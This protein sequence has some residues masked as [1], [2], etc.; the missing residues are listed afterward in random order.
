MAKPDWVFGLHSVS[1]ILERH[2]E[3]ILEI[4]LMEGR[5]DQ[6][7]S[8]V[9]SLADQQDITYRMVAKKVL[10]DIVR[11]GNHQGVAAKCRLA[12]P[13]REQDLLRAVE[14]AREP[15]LFLVLDSVTDPQ[16]LGGCI[17]SL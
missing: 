10:D 4:Y 16:N 12:Q 7:I 15:V 17:R 5:Q 6:R 1:A 13:L 9:Q 14:E 11:D 8:K 2:P 3:R